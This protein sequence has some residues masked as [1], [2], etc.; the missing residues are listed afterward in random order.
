MDGTVS[1]TLGEKKNELLHKN[2]VQRGTFRGRGVPKPLQKPRTSS[3]NFQEQ[4]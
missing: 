3:Q 2:F 4:I 1:T